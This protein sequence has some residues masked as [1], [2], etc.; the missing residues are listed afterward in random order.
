MGHFLKCY[1]YNAS[2]VWNKTT[3]KPPSI[4]EVFA[5]LKTKNVLKQCKINLKNVVVDV[6]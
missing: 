1:M 3:Q 6:K 4:F 5:F 2:E